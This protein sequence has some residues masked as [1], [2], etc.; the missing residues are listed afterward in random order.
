MRELALAVKNVDRHEDDAEL[1]AGEEEVDEVE[2]VGEVHAQPVAAHEAARRQR[3]RH[4]IAARV[5]F[6]EGVDGALPF[7]CGLRSPVEEGNS[8]AVAKIHDVTLRVTRYGG[9]PHGSCV[10]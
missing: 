5:D 7:E 4:A 6:A 8:E 10:R 1:H 3:M 2:R 9:C